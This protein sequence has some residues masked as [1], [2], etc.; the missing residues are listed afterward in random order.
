MVRRSGTATERSIQT[1][2]KNALNKHPA[3]VVRVRSA[4]AAGHVV[5]DPDIYGSIRGIHVEIEVK[6]PGEKPERIQ[7]QQLKY[8]ADSGA[9]CCWVTSKTQALAFQKAVL[10][11]RCQGRIL[12]L[13]AISKQVR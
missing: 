4:D 12:E 3:T 6:R 11:G 9:A 13:G 2:V 5:G 1:A 10:A 8:W 7:Y